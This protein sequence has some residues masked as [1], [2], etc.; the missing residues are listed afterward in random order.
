M[1]KKISDG[2]GDFFSAYLW[3]KESESGDYYT[4][5]LAFL[6]RVGIP[7]HRR[8]HVSKMTPTVIV[9]LN[10]GELS[11]VKKDALFSDWSEYEFDEPTVKGDDI[12]LTQIGADSI[13]GTNSPLFNSGQG[14]TG[15]GVKVGVIAAENLIFNS[16]ALSLEG[17]DIT[18]LPSFLPP[19]V[20]THPTA[21]LSQI[22]GRKIEVDGTTYFGASRNAEAFFAPAKTTKNVFEAIERMAELGVRV[23]NYSA[24]IIKGEYSDFDRQID[25][26]IRNGDFLFVTVSGNSRSMSSPGRAENGIAVGNLATKNYPDTPLSSPWSVWCQSEDS[27]SGYNENGV[28]K[29]DLV[30]PGA[31]VGY[32]DGDGNINFA[33]F[34]TSFACPWVS[35]IA[36]AILEACQGRYTYL[37]VKALILMSCDTESVSTEGNPAISEFIRLRSGYGLLD[38]RRAVEILQ[39]ASI[40]EGI[41]KGEFNAEAEGQ[42]LEIMLVFEKS[43]DSPVLTVDGEEY[44]TNGQNTLKIRKRSTKSASPLSVTGSGGRFSLVVY[45]N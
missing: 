35:G 10:E 18:V 3:L 41:L 8:I 13:N 2:V 12:L 24:G 33:N 36:C 14:Y 26:L 31:W 25:R 19:K 44:E 17:V 37:T 28:H 15:K 38:G 30:A 23:I 4:E 11:Q 22:V 34:G 43:E 1:N 20:N 27:C 6:E 39:R 7:S 32:G 29:P 9:L 16:D 21:V 40:Y 45:A 42:D 5:N